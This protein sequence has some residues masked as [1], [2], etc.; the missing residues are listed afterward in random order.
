[1]SAD[2]KQP[3]NES[4]CDGG[5]C[6]TGSKSA[7]ACGCDA[8]ANWVCQRHRDE[9]AQNMLDAFINNITLPILDPVDYHLKHVVA[10][11]WNRIGRCHDAKDEMMNAALG[12]A[13]EAGEIADLHKKHFYHSPKDHREELLLELGDVLYYWNKVRD[14]WGF[15]VTEIIQANEKKLFARYG[16]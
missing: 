7:Q 9:K 1:M 3:F 8:G 12:L 11:T 16:V 4:C 10:K 15:S 13:G 6:S 14:L 2:L 5:E